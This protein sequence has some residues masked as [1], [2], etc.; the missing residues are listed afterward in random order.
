MYILTLKNLTYYKIKHLG[1]DSVE[2]F[3]LLADNFTLPFTYTL[4]CES[5]K[6]IIA[7]IHMQILKQ[8]PLT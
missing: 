8:P 2:C 7:H 6:R 3:S 5:M 1:S 4:Q